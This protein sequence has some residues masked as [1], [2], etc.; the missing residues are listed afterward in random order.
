[1]TRIIAAVRQPGTPIGGGWIL[2][3][4]APDLDYDALRETA[5]ATYEHEPGCPAIAD[6]E[7]DYEHLADAGECACGFARE[8]VGEA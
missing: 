2:E 8:L 3:K 4:S 5:W 6:D 7:S 1:M